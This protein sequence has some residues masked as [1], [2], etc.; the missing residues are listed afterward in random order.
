VRILV[1][2]NGAREHAIIKSLLIDPNVKTIIAAPGN[3]G[4]AQ[5]V[6]T[7][8][9][10]LDDIKE[11]SEFA[12]LQQIDL[13]IVGPEKPLVLG[14]S[15]A[16]RARGIA[17]FGPSEEAAQLESSKS[18]AKDI[19]NAA[20]VPT[21][22]SFTCISINEVIV[23]LEQFGA[24]YVV[25]NDGLAGG[26]GVVVTEN[27]EEAISH[28]ESCLQ[29]LNSKVVIEEFLKGSEISLFCIT[30][31]K[32]VLALDAAQDYKRVGDN[33][34]GLNT[35][36]MGAYSPLDWAP[37]DLKEQT[38]N[39]IAMPV[40][41][42]MNRRGISFSGLLYVGL[43]LTENGLKVIEFNVRF[44]DPETQVVLSRLAT[45]LSKVLYASAVGELEKIENLNWR[46]EAC[47]TVVL[48]AKNYP[49]N[50]VLGDE[51]TG[52]GQAIQVPG[53]QIFHAGT[54]LI[55][56]KI[57][58]SGGRVLSITAMGEDLTIARD[59]VYEALKKI[60]LS[61]SHYRTDIALMK[62]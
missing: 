6:E 32:T 15:D 20:N 2:G 3:A 30:D 23:A 1:L 4:I 55:N 39:Q 47:V 12:V 62:Q 19:M 34:T 42:E 53:V 31:G 50:P 40:I 22:K 13:V 41:N 28:A 16:I 61:G 14:I 17:C 36:G 29:E 56:G 43:V 57:V 49:T 18:F 27:M 59:R 11:I 37:K 9:I 26:K 51:I 8:D 44:G 7:F 60:E 10:N 38:V 33:N 25:K 46:P 35:G 24:P 48:A 5:D 45:P 52:L 58:S 54:T 21:A